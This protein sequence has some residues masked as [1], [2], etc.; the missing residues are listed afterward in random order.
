VSCVL[1]D[2][3]Q[4]LGGDVDAFPAL[5]DACHLVTEI[6]T[7]PDPV[8]CPEDQLVCLETAVGGAARAAPAALDTA[9]V[10]RGGKK[11]CTACDDAGWIISW[12]TADS[13]Y[14]VE[15]CDTCRQFASDSN[16]AR[17]ARKAGICCL[18]TYPCYLYRPL[19]DCQDETRWYALHDYVEYEALC[20][21]PF[22]IPQEAREDRKRAIDGILGLLSA[23]WKAATDA[24]PEDPLCAIQQ[25]PA[26]LRAC[27]ETARTIREYLAG[28]GEWNGDYD[29]W[30]A[31]AR[32]LE[33]ICSQAG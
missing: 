26:A 32:K 15:C 4:D 22:T 6:E 28:E 30:K 10:A 33:N 12:R 31:L 17:A 8:V 24:N 23:T 3:R 19:G 9:L 25:L 5:L 27:S 1:A 21:T 14:A 13:R 18:I 20:T 7:A 11:T 29:A 2:I 16:A